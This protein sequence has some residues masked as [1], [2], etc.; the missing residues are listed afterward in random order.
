MITLKGKHYW[1]IGASTGIG[2]ELALVLAREGVTLTI[3]ARNQKAL[4]EL[5]QEMP[6]GTHTLRPLDVTDRDATV[7]AFEEIG[8]LDGLIYCAGAY[9]PMTADELDLDTVEQMV[10]VNLTGAF[11]VLA[12]LVPHFRRRGSGH[13][14]LV[15]SLAGYGGLPSSWGYGSSKAGLIHL[16]ESLHCDLHGSGVRVQLCN[17][18]FVKSR[19][20]SKNTFTMPFL[21]EPQDAA[22]RIFRGMARNRF[23]IAFP[24]PMVVAFKVF[25]LLPYRLYLWL[26]RRQ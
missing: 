2:R 25:S 4:E 19:L 24:L 16:A 21:M 13:I 7:K 1:L 20:T 14:L 18:G 22:D 6:P 11:R 15:G 26:L 23:E 8:P 5:L 12:P 9:E 17:P 3:S 10:A